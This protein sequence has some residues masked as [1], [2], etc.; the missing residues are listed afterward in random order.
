MVNKKKRYTMHNPVGRLRNAMDEIT[1]LKKSLAST[2]HESKLAKKNLLIAMETIRK[3]NRK[4]LVLMNQ[5]AK[6]D[7]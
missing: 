6:R 3:L 7:S 4:L 1:D 5:L 2:R